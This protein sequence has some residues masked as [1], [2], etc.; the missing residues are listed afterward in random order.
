MIK[1][2]KKGQISPFQLFSILFVSRIVVSLTYI[3]NVSV[4][5]LST[6]LLI[7]V[8]LGLLG[9][10]A[11]CVPICLCIKKNKNPFDVKWIAVLYGLFFVFNAALS[12]T[13]FSYFATNRFNTAMPMIVYVLLIAAA[14]CYAAS[15]GIEPMGRFSGVC[16]ISLLLVMAIVI[17]FNG[18][19]VDLINFYPIVENSRANIFENAAMI[20]SNTVEPALVAALSKRVNGNA[21]KPLICSTL[22]VFVVIFLLIFMCMGVMGSA[23][24]LQAYPIFTLFQMASI[25]SLSRLDML[26]TAFWMLA[27]FLKTSVFIYAATT[28]LKS[29]RHSVNAL[30]AAILTVVISALIIWLISMRSVSFSKIMSLSLSILFLVIIPVAFLLKERKNTVET[31]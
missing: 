18:K 21:V 28:G 12:I 13:R 30:G 8:F 23:A 4:G 2:Y 29:S 17:I 9:A 3:Q 19:N 11:L 10:L 26:H 20:A 14:A 16:S 5:R 1:A 15:L 22:F 7:S 6:D 25:G 24:S 31:V 27:L